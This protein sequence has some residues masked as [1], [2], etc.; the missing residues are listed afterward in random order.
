MIKFSLHSLVIGWIKGNSWGVKFYG[1]QVKFLVNIVFGQI[2]RISPVCGNLQP[3]ENF[4]EAS[5]EVERDCFFPLLTGTRV[6]GPD[7][8]GGLIT[9]QGSAPWP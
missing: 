2:R 6:F 8:V 5:L 7:P 9:G 1:N 4:T 3:L